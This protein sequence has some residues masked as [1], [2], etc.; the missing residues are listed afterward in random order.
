LKGETK[1][2]WMALCECAA[3]EQDSER[4]IELIR[5]I[6]QMLDEK[7]KRLKTK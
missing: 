2:H 1:E 5:Q 7:E 3:V 6:N 4:L